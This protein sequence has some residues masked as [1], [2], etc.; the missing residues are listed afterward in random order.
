MGPDL[1][2]LEALQVAYGGR[3]VL[4]IDRLS[5]RRGEVLAV[6]G[7]S[8]AGKSTLLRQLAFLESPAAGR[9]FF[10]REPAGPGMG[11]DRRRRVTAVFQNPVMLRRSV[12]ANIGYGPALRGAA[13][14]KA[15]LAGWAER[16]GLGAVR[17]ANARTLSAGEAQ[18]VA[19]ARALIVRPEALL[20]DEPTANLDPAN[21]S[22]IEQIV[23]E[24]HA[25]RGMT[26]VLVTHNLF[27]ARRMADRTL[28]LLEGRVVET[29]PTETFFEAPA[30]ALTAAFLRGEFVY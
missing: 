26:I 30:E 23:R 6:V 3:V 22:Q 16:I 7:P 17:H 1:Y 5:V 4:D 14:S 20:L 29:A 27:Q 9:L 24:E 12:L 28:L 15:E 2:T 8:G 21:A 25:T 18:R 11:L 13:C 19:L 10:D